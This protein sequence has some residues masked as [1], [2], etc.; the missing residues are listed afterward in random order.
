ML[1]SIAL[2]VKQRFQ[3]GDAVYHIESISANDVHAICVYG[4]AKS[5]VR[6]FEA[7]DVSR[8]MMNNFTS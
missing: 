7:D 4:H 1:S 6:V 3:F 2:K 8:S 5:S